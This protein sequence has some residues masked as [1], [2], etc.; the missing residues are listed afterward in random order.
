MMSRKIN[1]D[2]KQKPM[3]VSDKVKVT[4]CCRSNNQMGVSVCVCCG[5][6]IHNGDGSK[7]LIKDGES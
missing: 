6:N 2:V 5:D 3:C 1:M 7:H 4:F